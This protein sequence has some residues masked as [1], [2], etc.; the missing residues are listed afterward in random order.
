MSA[1][2]KEIPEGEYIVDI[3]EMQTSVDH[4]NRKVVSWMLKIVEGPYAES[5]LQKRYYVV[6]AKVAE[7]LKKELMLVGVD[8]KNA[9]EFESKKALSYGKRIRI[10]AMANDQGFQSLYVK[11]VIGMG[12]TIKPPSEIVGW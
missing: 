12:E 2:I 5:L 3:V 8:A 11:D 1:I 9:Q 7:H 10:T 4:K 6:N